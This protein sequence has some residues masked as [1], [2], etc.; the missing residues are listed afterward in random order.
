MKRTQD[1]G[2]RVTKTKWGG[3]D[4]RIIKKENLKRTKFKNGEDRVLLRND[5]K[6][7]KM[8][9][10]EELECLRIKRLSALSDS[11]GMN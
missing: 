11:L 6:K 8:K 3:V 7:I 5:I 4:F 1:S 10:K 2:N 9:L